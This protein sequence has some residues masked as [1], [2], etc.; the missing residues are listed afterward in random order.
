M[1][2]LMLMIITVLNDG[3]L[4]AIGYDNVVASKRPEVWNLPVLFTVAGVLAGVAMISSLLIL[5]LCFDSSN[6]EGFFRKSLGLHPLSYAQTISVLYLK[7]S[8]SDFLTLFSARTNENYLWSTAPSKTLGIAACISLLISSL[9]ASFWPQSRP[10]N[11][12][13]TGLGNREPKALAAFVWIYCILW[14][15]AQDLCKVFTYYVLKKWNIFDIMEMNALVDPMDKKT[16]AAAMKPRKVSEDEFS[17]N[18]DRRMVRKNSEMVFE[19]HKKPTEIA[20]IKRK[21]SR[22]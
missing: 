4:I 3:T 18:D 2:V 22:M 12:L 11:I 17:K 13:V 19:D 8:V 7:V 1:P 20:A 9:V 14:W 21:L 15:I 16:G 5:F 10:D 6:P